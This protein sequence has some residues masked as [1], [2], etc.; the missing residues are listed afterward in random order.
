MAAELSD[1]TDQFVNEKTEL[2][3]KEEPFVLCVEEEKD[4]V[5]LRGGKATWGRKR[6]ARHQY[7]PRR[8][9]RDTGIGDSKKLHMCECSTLPQAGFKQ[10]ALTKQNTDATKS[11]H[12]VCTN[13]SSKM[14][15]HKDNKG[16]LIE[17]A[18][19]KHAHLEQP[20]LRTGTIQQRY[21]VDKHNQGQRHTNKSQKP[22]ES[23]LT[24]APGVT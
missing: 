15:K 8:G 14:R 21:A 9:G 1:P 23:T 17:E 24:K 22:V 13:Q 12:R 10:G 19:G 4:N 6:T 2:D 7:R 5:K 18:K 20:C 16:D 3:T 11:S